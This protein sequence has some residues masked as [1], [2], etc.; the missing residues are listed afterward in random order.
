MKAK[1]VGVQG[2]HFTNNSGEEVNGTKI[3]CAF[4]DENVE[5]LRTADF[6]LKRWNHPSERY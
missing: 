4:Q 2:I 1:L 3:Y 5:G 6:F